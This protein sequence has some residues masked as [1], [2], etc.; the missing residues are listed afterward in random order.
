MNGIA[1]DWKRMAT[2]VRGFLTD[3][4][5]RSYVGFNVW[6]SGMKEVNDG[7]PMITGRTQRYQ[8]SNFPI[9]IEPSVSNRFCLMS[10][11]AICS[12][13]L[14]FDLKVSVGFCASP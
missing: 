5:G 9:R 6:R 10:F 3:S 14:R 4:R 2:V 1:S 7:R 12:I 13:A 8:Q 11:S